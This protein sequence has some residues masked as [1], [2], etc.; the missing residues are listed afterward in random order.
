M[1]IGQHN[2]IRWR[3]FVNHQLPVYVTNKILSEI[4]TNTRIEFTFGNHVYRIYSLNL[5]F[6]I[7][8]KTKS[9]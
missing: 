4:V 8:V 1:D 5:E 9:S 3:M 7:I 2:Y 6:P